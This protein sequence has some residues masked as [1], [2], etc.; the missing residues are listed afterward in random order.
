MSSWDSCVMLTFILFKV[1]GD[2]GDGDIHLNARSSLFSPNQHPAVSHL[3]FSKHLH[4]LLDTLP[5][6][7]KG[8]GCREYLLLRCKFQQSSSTV[9]RGNQ[10]ALN[11]N[12][13]EAQLQRGNRRRLERRSQR[14][15][16]AGRIH[17]WN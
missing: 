14:I 7:R 16:G 15:N 6:Q 3:A 8:L 5:S 13:L 10:R 12:T 9:A 4:C 1:F 17:E 11:P 2:V